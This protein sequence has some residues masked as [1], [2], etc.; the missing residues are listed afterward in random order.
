M[1]SAPVPTAPSRIEER[2]PN[3][4]AKQE[5]VSSL[6][7]LISL[8]WFSGIGVLLGSWFAANILNINIQANLM[9]ILGLG[10]LVYNALLWWGLKRLNAAS[11]P[12]DVTYHWFARLQI[13]LDWLAVALLIH[14]S[15]V[16]RPGCGRGRCL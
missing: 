1:S 9:Y 7:W 6:S 3:A 16:G 15:G 2:E 4:L 13:G 10:L 5:L 12:A 8:R 14:C 11:S